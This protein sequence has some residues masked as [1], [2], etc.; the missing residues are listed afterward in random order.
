VL[1]V[2]A[3]L[4]LWWWQGGPAMAALGIGLA[5]WLILGSAAELADR[6]RAGRAG[7]WGR[8]RRLPRAALGMTVA[9]AGLGVV[10][11]GMTG[12]LFSVEAIQGMAPGDQVTVA[13]YRIRLDGIDPVDGPNYVAQQ[14]R[15]TVTDGRGRA[16]AMT[17]SKR[18]FT[19]PPQV[20]TE[21]AIHTTGYSDLYL[22]LGDADPA[23]GRWG[24]RIYYNPLVPW[25]WFGAG[26]ML[27][28]GVVSLSD[29]RY[30]IGAPARR[31]VL[32]AG[33]LEAA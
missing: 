14:A 21:S 4:M 27:V 19:A 16:L 7:A 24:V 17:P 1:S 30:R 33:P 25:I 11:L 5:A 10:I 2:A 31:P 8:L 28:G 18:R 22:V 23:T 20:I 13:G 15:F 29:R 6:I 32:A 12:S 9:H 26:F 3:A